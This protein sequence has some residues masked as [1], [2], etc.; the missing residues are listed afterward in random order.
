MRSLVATAIVSQRY[1]AAGVVLV[2]IDE[3]PARGPVN[4]ADSLF[5]H[6]DGM[7]LASW[8]APVCGSLDNARKFLIAPRPFLW[9]NGAHDDNGYEGSPLEAVRGVRAVYDALGIEDRFT[10]LRHNGGHEEM[11]DAV[12]QLD[13][14]RARAPAQGP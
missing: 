10:F 6:P 8:Y 2:F 12:W 7:S 3:P 9:E 1:P 14:Y 4:T 5:H 13:F 11:P